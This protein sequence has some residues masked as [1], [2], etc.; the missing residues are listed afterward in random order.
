MEDLHN[1]IDRYSDLTYQ[2]DAL[3]IKKQSLIDE[4]ITPEIKAKIAEIDSEFDPIL[5][6]LNQNRS[7]LEQSIKEQVSTLGKT[8]QGKYHYFRWTR[9]RVTWDTRALDGYA[10]AHPEILRFRKEGKPVISVR[11]I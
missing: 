1:Q 9:P 2:H 7:A 3:L 5:M 10:A 4:V 8:V 11:K 6:Q